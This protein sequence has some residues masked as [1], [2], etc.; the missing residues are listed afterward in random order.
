MHV[1]FVGIVGLQFGSVQRAYPTE[2]IGGLKL[3]V[4]ASPAGDAR[5]GHVYFARPDDAVL[6]ALDHLFEE[7]R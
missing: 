4:Q 1:S 3:T 7:G 2:H 5:G 6:D